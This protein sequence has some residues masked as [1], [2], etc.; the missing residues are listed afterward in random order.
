MRALVTGG[1][2][3]IGSHIVEALLSRG[4]EVAVI[5]SFT[6]YYDSEIKRTTARRLEME[7]AAVVHGDLNSVDLE[8]LI[9]VDVIFHQ[10]GQPGV[11]KSW[12]TEFAAY[13]ESNISATQRLLEE[14][15]RMRTRPKLIYASSSSVYGTAERYPTTE[16]DVPRPKSPYGVSKLAAEHLVSLYAENFGLETTSLRYFTVYG[17]R[18]RPDMAFDRFIRAALNR[19]ELTVYG[20][21]R[22]IRDFTYVTD[23]VA[24]NLA[25]ADNP[26][27]PG[28]VFNIS[29]GSNCQLNE[30]LSLI[31][32]TIGRDLNIAKMAAVNGDVLQTGGD[33]SLIRSTIG[34]SPDVSI[35]DGIRSQIQWVESTL[36]R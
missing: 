15:K 1:A 16:M 27:E 7:G 29:G 3:F 5:D 10:A 11:R 20:D 2:G 17:P 24:A 23:V 21:G 28:S 12:G 19:E 8:P 35:V 14:V 31:R 13:V 25:V 26:V 36:V 9:N 6:E 30:V 4:D 33:S 34:W 18:Q 32:D 22:Q